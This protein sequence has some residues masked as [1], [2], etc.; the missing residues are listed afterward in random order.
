MHPAAVTFLAVLLLGTAL[1]AWLAAR[2][3]AFVRAHRATVP[4]AFAG[5]VGLD[6]HAKAADYTV[7]RTRFALLA[8]GLAT[9]LALAWTLGGGFAAL[10]AATRH[11][12]ERFALSQ[13]SIG[14]LV[15]V[16]L[17]LIGELLE[18]PLAWWQA[19]RLEAAFGFNRTTPALFLRDALKS[20]LLTLLLTATL[21]A[22]ALALM[23]AAPARWWLWVWAL[24]TAFSLG[25]TL[26]YPTLIAPLF[27]RFSPLTDA[28][29]QAR[30]EA[31]L[32]R[33]GFTSKGVSVMDA[34]QR[35]AHGNAYFA[36]I[37]A[38]KRIVLFDTLLERLQPDEV[39][40][41]LA[42]ELG[43]FRLKHVHQRLAVGAIGGLVLLYA[44]AA[45]AADVDVVAALGAPTPSNH[46]T[47]AL[48][49]LVAPAILLPLK[50]LSAWWSRRHEFEADDYARRM[51]DAAALARALVALYRDNATTL[52]P[53]PLFS[54]FHDSH[55]P[56]AARLARLSAG[57]NA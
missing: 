35:S 48:L 39:E 34:S 31:L 3:V 52:T 45:M 42:H 26:A 54:A 8:L 27:N 4:A 57:S 19:F 22:A 25:M 37:G 46:A 49:A 11:L 17:V 10:D 33:C 40:A 47:L 12:A 53:D 56:P 15:L 14:T 36:G 41:V 2:Q 24:V 20:M 50:P 23:Q 43:H 1:R 28:A 9:L 6:A 16:G 13:I 38:A 44:S 30:I 21:A 29:L 5:S 18:L 7:A 32:A 51:S 55:P